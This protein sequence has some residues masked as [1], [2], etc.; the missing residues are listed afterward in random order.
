MR[1]VFLA[2]FLLS[3][4]HPAFGQG[5]TNPQTNASQLTTGTLPAARLTSTFSPTNTIDIGTSATVLAPR[6]VYAGT[7]VVAPTGTFTSA[8]GVT[9]NLTMTSGIIAQ[10]SAIAATVYNNFY[11]TSESGGVAVVAGN[12]T[13]GG[14]YGYWGT[15]LASYRSIASGSTFL[16]SNSAAGL[17]FQLD[18]G[19]FTIGLGT[20]VG[21]T[22]S[23]AGLPALPS[24]T[25]DATHTDATICVDTTS[26]GLYQGSGALG[27][28]LGTS[29]RQF[30]TDFAPMDAGLA[31]I[32][33]LDLQR[34]RYREGFGDNG[35]R[36][37]YGLMAQD[38]E[39]VL[40]DLA[41]HDAEGN[42]I[43]YDAG[44][45]LFVS[46]RAIQELEARLSRIESTR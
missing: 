22:L 8:L 23:T 40:P 17:N 43:N 5:I 29:G 31:E 2:L 6:T 38:V 28:C 24:I 16:F 27:I 37:H 15:S 25:S 34:F 46:L 20:N 1:R 44:A 30:K 4:F 33:K 13:I 45:L 11:N 21:F 36:L 26:K 35:V 7:S 41:G 9:G 10:T 12:G 18:A 19:T 14:Q 42:T 3:L 39:K 32:S